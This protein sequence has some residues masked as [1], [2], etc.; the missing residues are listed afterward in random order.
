M[1]QNSK[2]RLC[3]DRN[4]RINHIISECSKLAQ[5]KYKTIH[6][7]VGKV[8]HEEMCKKL[9]FDPTNKWHIYNPE[10][11]L[12]DEMDKIPWDFEIQTGHLIS[13]RQPDQVIIKKE[14]K[15]EP[16]ELLTL[17]SKQTTE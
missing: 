17:P 2:C 5:E 1:Q 8:I 12:E 16:A 7:W 4:K 9:K 6:D 13:A 14:K 3:G 10:S 15:R 11:V